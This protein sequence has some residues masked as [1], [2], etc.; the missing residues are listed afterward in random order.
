MKEDFT[1]LHI[2]PFNPDLLPVVLGP[3]LLTSAANI[4]FN[5][6]QTFPESNYGY[7]DLPVMD[8]EKVKKRVNGAILK[9]KRIKVEEARPSKRRRIEEPG[10]GTTPPK[11]GATEDRKRKRS[12]KEKKEH[13]VIPGHLLP[14]NRKVK[15]GWTEAYQNKLSKTNKGET[16]VPASKYSDKDEL[17]FRTKLPENRLDAGNQGNER[18]KTK[19]AQGGHVVHEFAKST[20]QP[21][22]LRQEVGLGIKNNLEYMEGQGWVNEAGETVEQ[23]SKRVLRQRET[24]IAASRSKPPAPRISRPSPVP[25]SSFSEDDD[26]DDAASQMSQGLQVEVGQP[27][28]IY[29]DDDETSSSGISSVSEP[30]GSDDASGNENDRDAEEKEETIE[31]RVHPLEALFKKPK[32]PTSDDIAKPSLEVSTSF[33]FFDPQDEDEADE[34]PR[35]PGTPFSSQDIRARG[36]RSAAPTPDTAY[37]SRFN[38]Y[39]STGLPGDEVNDDDDDDELGKSHNPKKGVDSTKSR[40]A[41]PS[42]NQ[43]EFEKKFWEN[44]GE[45]NR[46]WKQRRRTV[47]KEKRQ[48]ENKVHKPKNW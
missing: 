43:S 29:D 40:T 28:R 5:S 47:L 1:R 3:T 7:L 34:E 22:F 6:I 44:R 41:T 20:K 23:E 2:T 26:D 14:A 35:I 48:R 12:K 8:A 32:K 21:S 27:A 45:N 18:G 38:S 24:S 36:L 37:P 10:N 16:K 9:G 19:Q 11:E 46:A 17:L 13:N 42:R 25:S 4:C 15:R 33:S 31:N 39:G 30:D